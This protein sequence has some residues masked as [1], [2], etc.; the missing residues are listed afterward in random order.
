MKALKHTT[1]AIRIFLW[2]GLLTKHARNVFLT[3]ATNTN[4][5]TTSK[6]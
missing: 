2:I 1:G 6:T 3:P 4:V 5:P